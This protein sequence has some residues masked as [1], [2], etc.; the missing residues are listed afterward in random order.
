ME[1]NGTHLQMKM[2]FEN[3]KFVE[4]ERLNLVGNNMELILYALYSES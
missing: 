4:R 1:E 3:F 2:V